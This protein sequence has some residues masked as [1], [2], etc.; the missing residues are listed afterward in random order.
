MSDPTEINE[1]LA[2]NYMLVDLRLRS[3]SGKRT[4]R[5]A[6]DELLTSKKATKDGGS[7][8]TNL[9]ASAGAELKEVH[10][11][12]NALRSFVY[13]RTLPWSTNGDDAAQRGERLLAAAK[14]MEFLV[15]LNGLKKEYDRAVLALA[16]IW[17][18]RM[19]EAMHNLGE[20]ADPSAYPDAAQLP[21]LFSVS[22]DL[23]PV[24]AV[25]DFSRLNVPAQL[26]DALGARSAQAAEV[27]VA[28]ALKDMQGRFIEELERIGKQ[29][30]KHSNGEKT[31]LYGSLITNMQGLVD[32][33]R[34]MNLN[35]NPKL[36]ELADRI[37]A[38]L[39]AHPIDVYRDDP[40]RAGDVARE[41]A[42]IATE[43]LE[44]DIFQ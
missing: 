37:E 20:L 17:P 43:V 19:A 35:Q 14:A 25:S 32:M 44:A 9:M 26:A 36:T 21:G 40:L 13:A 4:D 2:S 22:V 30:S 27:Q 15:E 33:A 28:N 12:G 39:L 23:R 1:A 3:W 11:L 5:K 24:P 38:K 6:S 29:L 31:R 34:N 41:A 16:G 42:A 7:F 18:Q 8:V 10:T